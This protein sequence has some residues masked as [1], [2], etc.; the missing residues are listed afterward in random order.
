MLFNDLIEEAL[1]THYDC[2]GFAQNGGQVPFVQRVVELND[3]AC[4]QQ[5]RGR[6]ISLRYRERYFSLEET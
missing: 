1:W 4:R 6:A 2:G 3:C 5:N